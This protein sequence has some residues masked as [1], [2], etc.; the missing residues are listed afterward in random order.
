[1][2]RAK[3]IVEAC[4]HYDD[5]ER[6]AAVSENLGEAMVGLNPDQIEVIMSAR[7]V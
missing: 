7:G 2:Q 6:L 5:P 3:A 1:V 4:T